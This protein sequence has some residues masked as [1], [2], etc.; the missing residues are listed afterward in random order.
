[1][2]TQA[3]ININVNS[4]ASQ[5]SVDKLSGSI[6]AAGGSAA[7]L[8]LEL[9]KTVQEL[10]QLEPGSKRFQELSVRAGQLR[11]QIADT[12]AVVGQLAGNLSER[13]VRGITGVVSIGVAGFQTLASGMALFGSE[14]EE[15]QQT[16]IRLQALMNLSQAI[17]TF[18]G[19]DQK[20][21]EVR[22][23]FQ[24]LTV[25]TEVQTVAQEGE[26][27]A[28]AQGTVA[29]T[30]LG[31]AMKALPIVAIAA[32]IGTLVYGIYQYVSANDEATKKEKE[33]EKQ[34]EALEKQ[35]KQLEKAQKDD[36]DAVASSSVEYFNLIQRLKETN[37]GSKERN[38]LIKEVNATYGTT[39]KNLKDET[40]F[41][42]QLNLSIKEY[43]ALQVL[44]VRQE[45]NKKAEI[46]SISNLVKVQDEL[47]KVNR[48]Y[49]GMSKQEIDDYD[50]KNYGVEV[51]SSTMARLAVRLDE[52]EKKAE[53]YA[54][55][56]GKLQTE[57]DKLTIN[58]KR[59]VEQTKDSADKVE[60]LTEETG[61]YA[62]LLESIQDVISRQV[63]AEQELENAQISRITNVQEREIKLLEK[64]YGDEK[65]KLIDDSIER[66][67][68]AFEEKFKEEGKTREE[69]DKGVADIRAKGDAN[70]LESERK[71]LEQKKLFLDQDIKNIEEK[72]SIQE[73]ITLNSITSIQDQTRLMEL[74][75]AKQKEIYDIEQS[76][77][78]EEKKQEAILDVK[79]KYLDN[80]IQLIKQSGSNQIAALDLLKKQ[81]LDNEE[82]TAEQR[83]EIEEKY[84]QEVLKVNEDTQD[85]IQD[86]IDG[87]K[88]GQETAL[89]SLEKSIEK[90]SE[91]INAVSDLFNQFS[92]TV[93]MVTEA[94]TKER[95]N[96][97]N[98]LYNYEK[99]MLENQLAEG[100][101]SREQ[102]DNKLLE[103]DQQK[104]QEELAL[105]RQAFETNK[106]LNVANAIINGAQSVLSTFANTPGGIILKSIAAGIAATLSAIQIGV[107]SNQQFTAAGGGIVPGSGSGMVDSVP[108]LLAPG[109]TVINA[110]SSSMY[111]ELLNQ[112]NM[113]GGGISLKPDLPATNK[114]DSDARVFGDNK[115]DKPLRAYVVESDVTDTQK[116]ISRIKRSAE[117]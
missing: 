89:E 42:N 37:A 20:L 115:M 35:T 103:L 13:L 98:G 109:E 112:V 79:K 88:E 5:E 25:A 58:G 59:Y 106:K 45:R 78:S 96:Q 92:N 24:S 65:Q 67:I 21:V 110:Q 48:E 64:Q 18:A 26:N 101:I 75:Y 111:P 54:I 12:N 23:A 50:L 32:A 44:K 69:Y 81:Q 1:M 74:E 7:S 86:A 72:Y 90:V 99:D 53:K 31:T 70:L 87:T 107:I 68:K 47:N 9:R 60:K 38:K 63:S 91:Y 56:N 49:A 93:S 52:A 71:L 2:A 40:A 66:E 6:N 33:A 114:S 73:E 36:R 8:R 3:S 108:S 95:E 82:L 116:R 113:A 97:I 27:I 77:M 76:V 19:L 100:I 51:Y 16:M 62:E 4:K 84:N 83:K 104:K 85:K 22:A 29:T 30:A 28:T 105:A 17:E 55:T 57:V 80:E 14:S 46:Q 34:R 43:I 61:K 11:D 15:L 117:F 10:Q 41:Q 102:Y 94:E 39:F